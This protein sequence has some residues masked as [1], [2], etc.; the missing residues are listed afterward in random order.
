METDMSRITGTVQTKAAPM[1]AAR[2]GGVIV[3]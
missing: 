3:P 2:V 1:P